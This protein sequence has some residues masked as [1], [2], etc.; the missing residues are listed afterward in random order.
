MVE[1]AAFPALGGVA[2]FAVL[3]VAV[4]VHIIDAVTGGA[5]SRYVLVL[6]IGVA[7]RAV[8]VFMLASERVAGLVVI[9]R[10][11]FPAIL[12][13]AGG[14]LC[15]HLAGVGVAG[16]V[17][18]DTL[19][20]GVAVGYSG[21]M[22]GATGRADMR[23]FQCIVGSVVIEKRWI[24]LHNVRVASLVIGVADPAI[25]VLNVAIAPMQSF[26]LTHVGIDVF[27]AGQALLTLRGVAEGGMTLVA[28]FFIFGMFLRHLARHHQGFQARGMG[29][30]GD[31]PADHANQDYIE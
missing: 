30:G 5:L 28:L 9:K 19:L 18:V 25:G 17:T 7:E 12:V 4:V 15:T 16:L 26:I 8:G 10:G 29:R 31:Y 27:V 23:T 20:R 22:A 3:A 14:A 11:L 1:I 24:E 13:V 2:L 21:F 6:L